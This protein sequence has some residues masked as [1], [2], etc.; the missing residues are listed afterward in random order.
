MEEGEG[1]RFLKL[2]ERTRIFEI[3]GWI[4]LAVGAGAMFVLL[5]GG[6][7]PESPRLA[8]IFWFALGG[9]YFLI[10]KTIGGIIQLLLE[11]ESRLRP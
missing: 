1:Y 11:I 9:V 7:T 3:L 2:T 4:S 8:G 5:F 6:G 10:F